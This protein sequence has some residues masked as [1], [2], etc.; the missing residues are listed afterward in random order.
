[1]ASAVL[2]RIGGGGGVR[3]RGGAWGLGGSRPNVGVDT[4]PILE[5][6]HTA[7]P[8]LYVLAW[9]AGS[10]YGT[11]EEADSMAAADE[12]VHVLHRTE[13]AGPRAPTSPVSVGAWTRHTVLVAM[14]STAHT[15]PR[16]PAPPAGTPFGD[17][18]LVIGSRYVP[19]GRCELPRARGLLPGRQHLLEAALGCGSTTSPPVP[20]LPA[21]GAGEAGLDGVR[22]ALLLLPV[23]LTWRTVRPGSRRGGADHVHS[24]GRIARR[25]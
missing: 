19:G 24:I 18:D 4:S 23:D 17:A 16:R 12:R 15:P 13:K 22:L 3:L 14:D 20:R 1:M 8:S 6:L 9:D 2:G 25:R 21:A 11:C 7:M 5:R 10:P